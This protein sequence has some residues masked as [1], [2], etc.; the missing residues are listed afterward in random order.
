MTKPLPSKARLMIATV[1]VISL[2]TLM[3]AVREPVTHS[4]SRFLILLAAAVLT[5]RFKVKLPGT[6]TTMSANLPVILLS[7]LQLGLL[8]SLVVALAAGFTQSF[9][10]SGN[11]PQL[12]QIAFN[13][14]ALLNASA[15]SYWIFHYQPLH[16]TVAAHM[17]PLVL[18]SLAYF[19]ANTT[20]M[21]GIIALA[22]G[23]NALALWH[24]LFLWSF[25]N[26]VLGAGVAAIVSVFS[27]A[28]GW[29]ALAA[30]VAV[31]FTVHQ[32]YKLYVSRSE[33]PQPKAVS[34]AAGR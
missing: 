7:I 1:S 22:E 6:T 19:V 27:M 16:N 29:A 14:C 9:S 4:W 24:K 12:V 30:V 11:K 10:S 21:A 25:P 13:A 8:G 28:A 18:A 31:L 23:G 15:L 26:Y 20:P 33:Q 5:S 17:L 2:C 3:L 32:S 34:M